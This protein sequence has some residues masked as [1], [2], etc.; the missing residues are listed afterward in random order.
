M[1][2]N[3]IQNLDRLANN[4][5]FCGNVI[6]RCSRPCKEVLVNSAGANGDPHGYGRRGAIFSNIKLI[7]ELF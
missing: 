3:L 2:T 7:F 6:S 5:M 1:A 4:L